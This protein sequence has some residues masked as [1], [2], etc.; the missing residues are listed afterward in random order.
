[1]LA[2]DKGAMIS[3][4]AAAIS[5]F[6]TSACLHDYCNQAGACGTSSMADAVHRAVVKA[7]SPRHRQDMQSGDRLGLGI[8]Q[9]GQDEQQQ[10]EQSKVWCGASLDDGG[11][12]GG[13]PVSSSRAGHNRAGARTTWGKALSRADR[14]STW[15][16]PLPAFCQ[17][18]PPSARH[19]PADPA[20]QG[21]CRKSIP[22]HP[23][24]LI[25]KQQPR[26]KPPAVLWQY[27]WS[28]ISAQHS[29][30]ACLKTVCRHLKNL[31]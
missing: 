3:L 28:A 17:S 13:R 20:Y 27:L 19:R 11:G 24:A 8:T 22:A 18:A 4:R 12:G 2:A 25:A 23:T 29:V 14:L 31:H 15:Y 30:H 1:M 16:V 7:V 10:V 9:E 21:F 26:G 5:T 6:T